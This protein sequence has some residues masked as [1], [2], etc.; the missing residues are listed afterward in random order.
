MVIWLDSTRKELQSR[1]IY[2]DNLPEI[3]L[4]AVGSHANILCR[5]PDTSCADDAATVA[6]SFP[7]HSEARADQDQS[8][9]NDTSHARFG[10]CCGLSPKAARLSHGWRANRHRQ[11]YILW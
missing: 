6:P 8:L 3:F 9:L 10:T 2:A 5:Q 4:Y 7:T 1:L 11:P